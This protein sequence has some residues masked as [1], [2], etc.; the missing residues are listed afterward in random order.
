GV[1]RVAGGGLL[2]GA[3]DGPGALPPVLVAAVRV[4]GRG[5]GQ[6]V[7][8]SARPPWIRQPGLRAAADCCLGRGSGGGRASALVAESAGGP[9]A[10][11][12]SFGGLHA[13]GAA[14]V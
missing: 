11:L 5:A 12:W 7:G 10:C 2:H 3:R 9:G 1:R 14:L 8:V 13:R 4:H 6:S